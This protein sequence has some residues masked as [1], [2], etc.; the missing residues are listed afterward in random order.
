MSLE[1]EGGAEGAMDAPTF[2]LIPPGLIR[3]HI[4]TSASANCSK[5][6]Y[7]SERPGY[8][9]LVILKFLISTEANNQ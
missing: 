9:Y 3:A 4:F 1:S 7:S 5:D 2:L 8:Q 6:V